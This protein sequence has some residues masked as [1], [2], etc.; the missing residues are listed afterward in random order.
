MVFKG[1]PQIYID[2]RADTYPTE[3]FERHWHMVDGDSNWEI[4]MEEDRIEA[5]MIRPG[6]GLNLRLKGH[7][8]WELVYKDKWSKLYIRRSRID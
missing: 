3:L 5:I 1:N 8:D 7:P 2:G 6:D 4:M